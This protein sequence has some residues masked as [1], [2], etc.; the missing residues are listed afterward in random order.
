MDTRPVLRRRSP[1]AGPP[2]TAVNLAAM[3][4]LLLG[5]MAGSRWNSREL[6][7]YA[8]VD[9]QRVSDILNLA[10]L[11]AAEDT[12]ALL[13]LFD[14]KTSEVMMAPSRRRRAKPHDVF[15]AP[16]PR[17]ADLAGDEPPRGAAGARL[18]GRAGRRAPSR[19]GGRA[20]Q[21]FRGGRLHR[22][23]A[24]RCPV[25]V[26]VRRRRGLGGGA[27]EDSEPRPRRDV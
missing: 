22:G 4:Y 2:R 27:V 5:F 3:R 1:P 13:G 19:G 23:R 6:A 21:R 11:P 25:A 10:R 14:I 20:G 15:P 12:L 9:K 24:R 8:G 17:A 7:D 26:A 18:P 16:G